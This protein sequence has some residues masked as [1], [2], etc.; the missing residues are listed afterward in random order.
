MACHLVLG[1]GFFGIGGCCDVGNED[2]VGENLLVRMRVGICLGR[3][4]GM[5]VWESR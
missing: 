4:K 5:M 2:G 3:G 1:G